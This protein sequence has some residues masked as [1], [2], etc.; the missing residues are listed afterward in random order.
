MTE[1]KH[2]WYKVCIQVPEL[3]D[4][5][6]LSY[7]DREAV[8]IV[9]SGKWMSTMN[10]FRRYK[11]YSNKSLFLS[12]LEYAFMAFCAKIDIINNSL[13]WNTN[14][15]RP[16]V[17]G[18][19]FFTHLYKELDLDFTPLEHHGSK[20]GRVLQGMLAITRGLILN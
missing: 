8:G 3:L 4:F 16:A 13:K 12:R 17:L 9:T 14:T 1:V 18:V 20:P 7:R 5:T 10:F 6:Q 19:L 15:L 2:A 11:Q